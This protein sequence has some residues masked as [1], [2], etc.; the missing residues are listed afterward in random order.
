MQIGNTRGPGNGKNNGT[1]DGARGLGKVRAKSKRQRE[2]G[3]GRKRERKNQLRAEDGK[4]GVA[5]R[6]DTTKGYRTA[7]SETREM[8]FDFYDHGICISLVPV[9]DLSM[10]PLNYSHSFRGR[11]TM[12][13]RAIKL[14]EPL[15]SVNPPFLPFL[16][17]PPPTFFYHNISSLFSSTSPL[18]PR[19][20]IFPIFPSIFFTPS[21]LPF[22][23]YRVTI[24]YTLVPPSLFPSPLFVFPYLLPPPRALFPPIYLS[25]YTPSGSSGR[26]PLPRPPFVIHFPQPFPRCP[27]LSKWL[28]LTTGFY[29]LGPEVEH[30]G[31]A[32]K[33]ERVRRRGKGGSGGL[34]R[35]SNDSVSPSNTYVDVLSAVVPERRGLYGA[36]A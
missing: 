25:A 24:L 1:G 2:R 18:P 7:A 9:V 10:E 30:A 5:P 27:T 26:R 32:A 16:R 8:P 14:A 19:F 12:L 31:E 15:H 20:P 6:L 3:G 23:C 17:P 29:T 36:G 28:L 13:L 33:R 34:P 11:A 22:H 35:Y 4:K 21:I